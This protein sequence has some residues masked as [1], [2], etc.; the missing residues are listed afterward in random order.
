MKPYEDWTYKD[1]AA[2]DK[3]YRDAYKNSI[4]TPSQK[5]TDAAQKG[6][7][8]EVKRLVKEE[9]VNV[10]SRNTYNCTTLECAA[11]GGHLQVVK[12]LVENGAVIDAN[13]YNGSAL[14][15]A[16]SHKHLDVAAYLI[17]QGAELNAKTGGGESPLEQA[18]Y[19]GNSELVKL[20]LEHGGVR[21]LKKAANKA[22]FHKKHEVHQLLQQIIEQ[23][24]DKPKSKNLDSK[25]IFKLIFIGLIIFSGYFIYNFFITEYNYSETSKST[26]SKLQPNTKD[27]YSCQTMLV[28]GEKAWG[29]S[30]PN[31][32]SRIKITLPHNQKIVKT[33]NW[34]DPFFEVVPA[35]KKE[36][37]W[38]HKSVVG[39]P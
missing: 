29:F 35:G 36:R 3:Y 7:L 20:I 23:Y 31:L 28:M 9:Y 32:K 14:K 21:G 17:A 11:M 12:F 37:I 18:A 8:D 38:V 33:G 15:V 24:S 6:N 19:I 22:R 2:E 26:Q 25:L 27:K 5:I 30:Q 39:C 1:Y 10:N 16:L 13:E 34:Q 4:G